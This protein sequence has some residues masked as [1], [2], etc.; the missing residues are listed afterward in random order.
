[1]CCCLEITKFLNI[2]DLEP[3]RKNIGVGGGKT[4]INDINDKAS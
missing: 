3:Q 4:K 2:S 1:M